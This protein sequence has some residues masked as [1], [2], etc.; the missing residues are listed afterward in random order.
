MR[1]VHLKNYLRLEKMPSHLKIMFIG[2]QTFEIA[3]PFI[4]C[5]QNKLTWFP[6]KREKKLV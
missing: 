5:P 6:S 1:V 3:Q 4:L 2:N